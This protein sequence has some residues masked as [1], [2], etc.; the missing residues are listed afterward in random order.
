MKN[1]NILPYTKDARKLA[2]Q[3][4]K[5]MTPTE[6]IFWNA[7]KGSRLGVVMRRQMPILDYIVDFYIK[8]IG[9]AIEIDGSSHDNNTLVDGLRQARIE[10]L[11]VNFVRFTNDQITHNLPKVILQ[12]K[13]LIDEVK[14]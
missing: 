8:D 4:R 5:N 9:L 10:K 3:L 2:I 11:G 1:H 12:L 13:E 7:T 14:A 6:K